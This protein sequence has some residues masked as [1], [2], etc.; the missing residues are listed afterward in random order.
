MTTRDRTGEPVELS[1]EDDGRD[2]P[3]IRVK[4]W[5]YRPARPYL[6][7]QVSA[8]EIEEFVRREFGEK[9]R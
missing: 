3:P 9:T 6:D 5:P 8:E 4:P 2:P 1:P 7:D